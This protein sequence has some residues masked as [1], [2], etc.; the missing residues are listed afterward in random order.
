MSNG[1]Y[2][3]GRNEQSWPSVW[4]CS[5]STHEP[6][7]PLNANVHSA[8][9]TPRATPKG[10]LELL[11][12]RESQSSWQLRDLLKIIKIIQV[13]LTSVLSTPN[14]HYCPRSAITKHH[15]LGGLNQWKFT[16]SQL[17]WLE[18]QNQ[19]VT[20]EVPSGVPSVP[21]SWPLVAEGN[22]RC[23][24][25]WASLT[26]VSASG[27]VCASLCESLDTQQGVKTPP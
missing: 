7:K 26:P 19:C 4:N 23:A 9:V 10:E 13:F 2:R 22:H 21:L 14:L 16:L 27:F 8:H 5:D 18:V 15:K 17:W 1:N 11:E 12:L 20:G 3:K 25:A 6:V 24:L